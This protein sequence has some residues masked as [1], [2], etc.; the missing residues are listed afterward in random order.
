MD[1]DEKPAPA[2]GSLFRAEA[3]KLP[4]RFAHLAM[5]R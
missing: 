1:T 5:T 2:I 4:V 3:K